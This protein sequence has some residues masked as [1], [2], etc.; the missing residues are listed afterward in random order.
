MINHRNIAQHGSSIISSDQSYTPSEDVGFLITE[1]QELDM[2]KWD[3]D[4]S[5]DISHK[6]S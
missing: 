5:V 6:L 4:E 1:N 3:T 2:A